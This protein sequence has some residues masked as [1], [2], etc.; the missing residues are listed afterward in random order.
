MGVVEPLTFPVIIAIDICATCDHRALSVKHVNGFEHRLHVRLR[1][2]L[3]YAVLLWERQVRRLS[4]SR[5]VVIA[6]YILLN[7]LITVNR[8]IRRHTSIVR[9]NFLLRLLNVD[10]G[11]VGLA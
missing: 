5:L 11:Q 9:F 8:R 10:V 2:V 4:E 7:H 1:V 3:Q 6:S